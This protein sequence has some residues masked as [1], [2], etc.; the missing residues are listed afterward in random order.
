MVSSTRLRTLNLVALFALKFLPEDVAKR[1]TN[2]ERF[3]AKLV[4][5]P[6]LNHPNMHR[7]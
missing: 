7:P 1:P 4:L 2:A 6:A 5:L 3:R